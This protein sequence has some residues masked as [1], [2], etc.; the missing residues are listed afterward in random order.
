MLGATGLHPI[1]ARLGSSFLAVGVLV[2][3]LSFAAS[4][5]PSLIPRS[6]LIQG[7]LSGISAALGYGIGALAYWL[8]T[9]LELPQL[10]GRV[11]KAARI[12]IVGACIAIAVIF[13]WKT[14]G[15][16]N[17]IRT[18][19]EL[20]PLDT[21][22]PFKIG[23]IA[24]LVFAVLM[25]LAFLFKYTF[26]LFSNW[27]GRFVPKRVSL[28]VG[29]L[30]A[31]ALFWSVAQ[32][33]VV[34]FA[35][36]ILDS[37]F[38]ELDARI[39]DGL[40]KPEASYKTGSEASLLSWD[41]L[42]RQGRRFVSSGPTGVEIGA[43]FREG[44]M[45]PI[46]VYVGMNSAEM[47][48]ERANLA[49]QELKRTGAFDRSILIVVVPTGT[50]M[51]DPGALDTVEY[52]HKGDVASVAMQYSYLASWL[53]LLV[54]PDYG[55]EAG[56]ALFREV[57]A[58]WS[59][60]PRDSRP[61]LYLH[62]LSLGA[63]NSELSASLYDIVADPFQGALWSGPPFPSRT[64]RSVT[65]GRNPGSP[66]WL[67]RFRDSSIFRFTNQNN[68]L[69]IPDASWGPI[70]IVYLQYASDP[71]TFFDAATLYREPDWMKGPRGPDVSEQVRWYPLIT[72][73]QLVVDMAIATTSPMGYGHVFAPQHYIDAWVAVTDPPNITADDIA[74]LK[75]LF[76]ERGP[77]PASSG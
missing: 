11:L 12:A 14:S 49:L 22:N 1:L 5:T 43:F 46:R 30:L 56:K 65:D 52:L 3:T 16:Q 58:Y 48:E 64:W 62:G 21:A 32:G 55:A 17:S 6:Y 10:R 35:L 76:R 19:M 77:I 47:A 9:Y 60:L 36:R 33:L 51:I 29:G 8:W 26:L 54:E 15:W 37:S 66:E 63:M 25:I 31:I 38:Q 68:A 4:L 71:I 45:D 50:G 44:G 39:E 72:M 74:R 59:S 28:V 2:G 53:S 70:R 57:Y 13:L 18:L 7:V 61:K 69:D 24:C 42:G 40:L 34:R 73:L 41:D 23:A 75:A 20:P 67:P 27:L